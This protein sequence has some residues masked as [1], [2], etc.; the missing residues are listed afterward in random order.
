LRY[1][2]Q[3]C[4]EVAAKDSYEEEIADFRWRFALNFKPLRKER[5]RSQEKFGERAR[6]HRT[7]IGNIEQG[8]TDPP[9]STLLIVADALNV[10]LDQLVK[11]LPVPQHRKPPP[12]RRRSKTRARRS[13]R[14]AK[15]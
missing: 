1:I 2:R 7:T 3:A 5:F 13:V 11:D 14:P 12:V 10:S 15:R 4:Q 9:L 6:L 8:K